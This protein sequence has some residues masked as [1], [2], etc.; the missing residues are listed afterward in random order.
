[1][2][3]GDIEASGAVRLSGSGPVGRFE[4]LEPDRLQ[5]AYVGDFTLVPD[6]AKA[7]MEEQ[8]RPG[9]L[10]LRPS[11]LSSSSISLSPISRMVRWGCLIWIPARQRITNISIQGWSRPGLGSTSW[12]TPSSVGNDLPNE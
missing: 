5:F 3:V 8:P 6:L 11:G 1:M 7:L 12:K 2:K 4:E 9:A 10:L